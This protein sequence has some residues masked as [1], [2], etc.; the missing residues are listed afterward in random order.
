MCWN[1]EVSLNTFIFGLV[2]GSII[3]FIDIKHLPKVI[4]L[5]CITSMQLVEYF[6][7]KNI[8]NKEA[9]ET[10]SGFGLLSIFAQLLII[11]NIYL[12]GNERIIILIL[13]LSSSLITLD[14]VIKN[15]KLKMEKGINGHLYWHWLDIPVIL[16][17]LMIF[18]YLYAGFR[19]KFII[20][21]FAS[22]LLII[23]LYSYY[24]YKTWGSMWCYYSN[25]MWLLVLSFAVLEYYNIIK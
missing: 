7:W 17:L 4:I 20:F 14:Y 21:I 6:A 15:D 5:L 13:L 12:K 19:K 23:S 16:I 2:C 1:A 3:F 8:N 18:F 10:V 11:N 25:L 24:K 9:I 22:I